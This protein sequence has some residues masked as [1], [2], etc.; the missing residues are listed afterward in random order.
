MACSTIAH[1]KVPCLAAL[2]LVATGGAP[3]PASPTQAELAS[4]ISAFTGRQVAAADVR[5]IA[6]SGVEEPTEFACRWQQRSSNRWQRFSGYLAVDG[7][8]WLLIDEPLSR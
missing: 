5:Q 2:A 1:M 4:A 6:C 8:N 7:Q 3:L